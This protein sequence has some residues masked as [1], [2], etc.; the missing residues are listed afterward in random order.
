[1]SGQPGI[2][3]LLTERIDMGIGPTGAPRRPLAWKRASDTSKAQIT[4]LRH[5]G[6]LA[7][8]EQTVM[9]GIAAYFNAKGDW[10]T[11]PELTRWLFEAGK[12]AR[13][14]FN[15]V[16]PRLTELC[17]GRREWNESKQAYE[18][19]GGGRVITQG[20]RTCRVTE[21]SAHPYKLPQVG[22]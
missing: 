3:G 14:D 9:D 4:E 15:L 20:R 16:R 2:P 21:R 1:M 7:D 8:R 18:L 12:I 22:E 19:V 6:T 17:I 13:E 11:A 10:P 5:S